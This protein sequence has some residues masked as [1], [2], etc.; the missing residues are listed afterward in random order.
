MGYQ[1]TKQGEE[2]K[3]AKKKTKK[4]KE[5]S[6]RKRKIKKLAL[7]RSTLVGLRTKAQKQLRL[8]ALRKLTK[9]V[10]LLI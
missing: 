4:R 6:A 1:F 8:N 3:K 9:E 10:S 7:L 2:P 5:N